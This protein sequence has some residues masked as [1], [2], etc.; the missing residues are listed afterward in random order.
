MLK[1]LAVLAVSLV[2]ISPAAFAANVDYEFTVKIDNVEY[3]GTFSYDDSSI[4]P[5]ATHRAV[6]LLTELD[7]DLTGVGTFGH[8]DESSANTGHLEFDGSGELSGFLFGNDCTAF[9]CDEGRGH[10]A[11]GASRYGTG[12]WDGFFTANVLSGD[13]QGHVTSVSRVPEPG[14][15][16]L[17]GLG[18]AGLAASRRRK[19]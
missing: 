1:T 14:S 17:L 6:G 12:Q 8:F 16:A 11:L 13:Q 15:L 4:T 18:L 2:A 10:W 9:G 7:F 5:G 3:T 19:H